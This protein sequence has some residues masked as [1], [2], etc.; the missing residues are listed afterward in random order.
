MSSES[1]EEH[2]YVIS[3]RFLDNILKA[4]LMVL[5][6]IFFRLELL[7]FVKIYFL[8]IISRTGNTGSTKIIMKKSMKKSIRMQDYVGVASLVYHYMTKKSCISWSYR[9]IQ[10]HRYDA[11][12]AV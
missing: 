6:D 12:L 7:V 2:H 8:Y 5:L 1:P 11:R 9:I 4:F 10:Y 3:G